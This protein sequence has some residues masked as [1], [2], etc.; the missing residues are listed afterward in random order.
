LGPIAAA[1]GSTLPIKNTRASDSRKP[2]PGVT[3]QRTYYAPGRVNLIGEHTD[4]SGGLVLPCAIDRGITLCGAPAEQIRLTSDR[5]GKPVVLPADGQGEADDWGRY[6]A[7]VA[8]ELA[9]AGR[10]PVGLRGWLNS[11][12]PDGRGLS[13]SAALEVC[14]ALA[15]CD[16]AEFTLPAIDLALLCQRAEWRA[17]GVPC[18]VMDQAAI[19][20]GRRQRALFLD[21]ASLAFEHVE[22]PAELSIAII[23]S[24][25]RREL[26]SSGYADRRREVERGLAGDMDNTTSRRLRHVESENRRVQETVAALRAGRHDL[27]GDLFW[28]SHRSLRDDFEVTTQRLD[29]LVALSY[30]DGAVAARMTG[31]GFG[32]AMVALVASDD[33]TRFVARVLRRFADRSGD[34]K[35]L[36]WDVVQA[37]DGARRL[38]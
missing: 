1:A 35:Q 11:D 14:L 27:L 23:D 28:Q 2:S 13:S 30:E 18:G 22:L 6:A 4:Y 37:G 8:Q 17:V 33:A 19:V 34:S 26:A 7:A 12:L 32:G 36:R 31:A 38:S 20:L 3:A 5:G 10:P 16:V 24:G 25:E 29:L 15:L 21:C 9:L